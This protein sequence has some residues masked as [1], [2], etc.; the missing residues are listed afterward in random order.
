MLIFGLS[1]G[2]MTQ[3]RKRFQAVIHRRLIGELGVLCWGTVE[4]NEDVP[5]ERGVHLFH[6]AGERIVD[7]SPEDKPLQELIEKCDRG[8]RR[9]VEVHPNSHSLRPFREMTEAGNKNAGG[10]LHGNTDY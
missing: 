3:N 5:F 8:I 2:G 6:I 1:L 4:L 7:E 10:E 9:D